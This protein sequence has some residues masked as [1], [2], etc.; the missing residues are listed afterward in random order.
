MNP[1]TNKVNCCTRIGDK[2]IDLAILESAKIFSGN[3]CFNEEN[4]NKF[5]DMGPAARIAARATLQDFFSAANAGN[6]DKEGV[7]SA[8]FDASA[9]TLRMPI[10][11]R[12]YTD[13]Y[14]SKNHA[15]NV[16]CMFRGPDNALQ[17]NW[18]H[19]PVGYH[20][21]A[22][23][24]VLDGTPI[25]RPKGQVGPPPGQTEIKDPSWSQSNRLDLELEMGTIIGKGNDLGNP[26]KCNDAKD[27]IFGYV[28][29][30]D[31]S[32]RDL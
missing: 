17:P 24:I 25:R 19:L 32:S 29:L 31:W 8:M 15:Y 2:V 21:R 9:V 12:D 16:G 6:A 28:L 10:F 26:I 3:Y 5:A 1:T 23:S 20:G 30:N 4:L 22:S 14:S 13:F 11:I 27:H 7:A 18:T